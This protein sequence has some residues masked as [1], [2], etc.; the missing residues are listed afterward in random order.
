M[1]SVDTELPAEHFLSKQTMWV[2]LRLEA[3]QGQLSWSGLSSPATKC[4]SVCNAQKLLRRLETDDALKQQLL[5]NLK[6]ALE[7]LC[8]SNGRVLITLE[9][10]S[11]PCCYESG[12]E[13]LAYNGPLFVNQRFRI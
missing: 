8:A 7:S 11:T 13:R 10:A 4:P 9:L 1:Q 6:A 3:C 2:T 5:Q 12:F